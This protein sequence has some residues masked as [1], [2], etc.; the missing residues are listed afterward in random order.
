MKYWMA[1]LIEKTFI[2]LKIIKKDESFIWQGFIRERRL[3]E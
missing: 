3:I 2:Y 1:L